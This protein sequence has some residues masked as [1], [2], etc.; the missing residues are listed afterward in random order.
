[1]SVKLKYLIWYFLMLVVFLPQYTKAESINDSLYFRII[2]MKD[3]L[4]GSTIMDFEQDSLG[5]I[6]IAT[7]DGLC[8]FDGTNFKV[9]KNQPGD[10]NSLWNNYVQNLYIDKNENLWIMTTN[11]MNFMDLRQQAMI[12]IHSNVSEGGLSDNSPTDIIEADDGAIYISSYYSG[13]SFRK[14]GEE[15]FSYISTTLSSQ[16]LSSSNISCLEI[17]RDSLLFIGTRDSGI[18][19]LNRNNQKI[20][21]LEKEIGIALCSPKIQTICKD[22]DVGIWIGTDAGLSYY[23]LD[24]KEIKNYPY[25]NSQKSF[26]VDREIMSLFVDDR[27]FLWMGTRKNGLVIIKKEDIFNDGF[28]ADYSQYLPTNTAGGLSYRTVLSIFKDKN[29]MIWVGT[30]GGGINLVESKHSRFGHLSRSNSE[31]NGLSYNKVWGLAEDDL[32]NV[33]IGT[34]GDG[35]N[36]WNR[37]EGVINKFKPN[38]LLSEPL[39]DNAIISALTDRYGDIWLGT[40]EGGL[41]RYNQRTGEIQHYSAPEDILVNDVRC[42]YEDQ[43]GI[44]W[45]GLN[46]GGIASFDREKEVFEQVPITSDYDVRSIFSM[47]DFLWLGTYSFGLIKYD[48]NQNKIEGFDILLKN[49]EI[50][51]IQ[52]IYSIYG[53]DKSRLWLATDNMGLC[54]YDYNDS[55]LKVFSEEKGLTNNKVHAILGDD[56]GNLWLSTNKGISKFDLDQELFINY[57]WQRGVQPQ[58]F[59]NGSKLITSD[60]LF[61]FGGIAGM[62]YFRPEHFQGAQQKANLQ[63]TSFSVLNNPVVPDEGNIISQSIEYR[64]EIELDHSHSFFAIDFQSLNYPLSGGMKYDYILE[65]YDQ[66]WIMAGKKTRATYKNIPAGEYVFRVRCYQEKG[67]EVA[68]QIFLDINMSPPFW[69]SIWAYFVYALILI[70]IAVFIFRYRLQSYQYK[71]RIA[72]EK[73]LRENQQKLHEERMDFFTNISHELRTPLTII[74]VALEEL[75]PV[76]QLQPK[77]KKTYET[78][79]KTSNRLMELLNELLEFRRIEKGGVKLQVEELELN[80]FL[81]EFLKD[82]SQLAKHKDI[83]LK[84]SLPLDELKLWADKDKFSMILNNLLSNA[85]KNT[86][87]GEQ[88]TINAEEKDQFINVEVCDSGIGIE[89]KN[90][91]KIFNR[92]YKLEEKSTNT[93]IGLA[94]TKSLVELHHGAIE[95]KSEPKKGSRFILNFLSGMKHFSNEDLKVS[96]EKEPQQTEESDWLEDESIMFSGDHEILLLI[97]DNKEIIDLL[98]DK[99]EEQYKVIKAY[100]GEEGVLLARKFGPDLIISDI[101]MP[102]ISGLEVCNTLKKDASTSHIPII[103]LTAKGSEKD[104][105]VGLN[106]G[107]D[108]YISKPFKFSI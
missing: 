56:F 14:K 16:P 33:W 105:I 41:N 73:K 80:V 25:S 11:G 32:G 18:D 35:V 83:K 99:F 96:V 55:S 97:D 44:L 42:I 61:C 37:K 50:P 72:Y 66:E 63:F 95:V 20:I 87:A 90:L 2:N 108:D 29:E 38:P 26:V 17:L 75:M 40:Y 91:K 36:I 78:A 84:V 13:I 70:L 86:P 81:R 92:Y 89:K 6:W 58:E 10:N 30:H 48:K 68:E 65:G 100:S 74:G 93:G 104:E 7:N 12:R 60:G 21:S 106:T 34:D 4:P 49:T 3:G 43:S 31:F 67:I 71:H 51:A 5:F 76:R 9:F 47:G 45:V 54:M 27:G 69:K 24:N 94:L 15:N 98:Q 77:L 8:R 59:H 101:M 103:L 57:N 107:A 1:M 39:S 64:P 23:N 102:G 88:I 79:L 28:L 52:T 19:I 46:R 85:F 53:D 62:N 82:F 22:A